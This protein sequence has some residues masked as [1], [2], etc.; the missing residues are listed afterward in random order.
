MIVKSLKLKNFRNHHFLTY[1]FGPGINVIT[2]SNAAGKTNVV[3]AIY[4]LSL[5]HSFRTLENEELV[6][7]GQE[8]A[9]IESVISEGDIDRKIYAVI[10]KNGHKISINNKPVRKLSELTKCA[11]VILFEPKDVLLFRGSPKDRRAFLDISIS[12]KSPS[13]FEYLNQAENLL[14]E[15]NELLKQEHVDLTLL[16]SITEMLIRVNKMIV[17]YRQ[18][19]VEDINDIL[20]KITRVLTGAHEKFEVHYYPF[21]KFNNEFEDNARNAYKKALESD[22]AKK[23]TTI[24][25]HREDFS[26]SLN[27][28]D[29][30]DFGS[31]G[32]N[33][34][35]AI[36]LKLSP[37]FLIQDRDKRPVIVLDDVMSELDLKHRQNLIQFLRRFEQVFITATRLEISDS[38]HYQIKSKTKEVF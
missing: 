8:Q 3:E 12:K 1:E 25:T 36:A 20:N 15:R 9:S 5:G 38:K 18:Q 10:D 35:A 14:K 24:G 29:I 27:D 6:Q 22:L 33:R 16:E 11:N 21:V 32:E 2:G 13:Y 34:I 4:Y 19:Y 7:K 31:Q 37:Y 28:R 26:L 30:A 17:K 23:V